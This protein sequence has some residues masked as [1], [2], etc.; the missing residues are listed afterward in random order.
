MMSIEYYLWRREVIRR[1]LLGD[2]PAWS[3]REYENELRCVDGRIAELEGL[4]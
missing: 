1:Y 3:A 4:T 2:P